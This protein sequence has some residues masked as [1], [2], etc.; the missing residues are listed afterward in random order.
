LGYLE[1]IKAGNKEM[2]Q[3]ALDV[4]NTWTPS[5]TEEIELELNA[6][7]WCRLGRVAIDQNSNTFTKIALYCA[8]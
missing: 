6:E 7:L 2:I 5:E 1:L 8:E 4:M 3:K